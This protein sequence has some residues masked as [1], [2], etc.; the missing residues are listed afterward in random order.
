[1]IKTLYFDKHIIVCEKPLGVLSQGDSSRARN[2]PEMLKEETGSY[3]VEAVHRLDKPVGGVMV[4]ARNKKSAAVL[5][6]DVKKR[7]FHKEYFAVVHGRPESDS[8][9]YRDFLFKDRERCKSY[10]VKTE[11][12]G[13]KEAILTYELIETVGDISLVKVQLQT[14]RTHQ[15]RVQF[16]SRG[17]PLVGDDKYGGAADK[18]NIGLFSHKI[19]FKHPQNGKYMEFCAYPPNT[20]PW[21]KFKFFKTI[22]DK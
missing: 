12:K 10:V 13:A 22:N 19:G 14:G 2:V 4:Y 21:Q 7:A 5:S 6:E 3:Y 17:M 18:C 9:E 16:S 8:G 20:Y 1:M 15:I 11:R